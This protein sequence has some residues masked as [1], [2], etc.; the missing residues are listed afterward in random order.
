MPD[1]IDLL[2]LDGGEFSTL[3]EFNKLYSR[4]KYILLDDTN[5]TKCNKVSK[6][7]IEDNNFELI[8]DE[9]TDD[10]NGFMAFRRK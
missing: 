2:L 9:Q 10:R 8:F 4:S 3:S 7:L 1:K 6:I 5:T